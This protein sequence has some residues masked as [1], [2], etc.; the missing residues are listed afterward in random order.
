MEL[1][2]KEVQPGIQLIEL[3]GSV[4][5][6][7]ECKRLDQAVD[8]YIQQNQNRVIFDFTRVTHID[9]SVIGLIVKSHTRLKKAGGELRLVVPGGMVEKVLKLTQVHRVITLYPSTAD[10]VSNFAAKSAET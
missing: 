2:K 10:A 3:S 6:G 8:E 9:S 4:H 5:T 7:S 1:Q